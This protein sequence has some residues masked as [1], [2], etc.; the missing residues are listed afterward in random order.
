MEQFKDDYFVGEA[1][2]YCNMAADTSTTGDNINLL[3]KYF[4]LNEAGGYVH[5]FLQEHPNLKEAIDAEMQPLF[6]ELSVIT[7]QLQKMNITKDDP[8]RKGSPADMTPA[9]KQP[10]ED[11]DGTENLKKEFRKKILPPHSMQNGVKWDDIVGQEGVK[12]IIGTKLVRPIKYP[13]LFPLSKTM[14][15]NILF[16]GAPGTGQ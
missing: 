2:N 13:D 7:A 9:N 8:S 6:D 4:Y 14:D 10:C 3:W 12:K 11:K 5:S 15:R 16:F 1:L